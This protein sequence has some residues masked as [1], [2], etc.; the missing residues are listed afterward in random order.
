M[1][2]HRI[3]CYINF[4]FTVMV[5]LSWAIPIQN[6]N[7]FQPQLDLACRKKQLEELKQI[8]RNS[9]RMQVEEEASIS[10][11]I[12]QITSSLGELKEN[13]ER[14]CASVTW[15]NVLLHQLFGKNHLCL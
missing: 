13:T 4:C 8:L 10:Q 7:Q 2:L 11:Q 5:L 9:S 15:T 3:F 6:H 14:D 1:N 12:D